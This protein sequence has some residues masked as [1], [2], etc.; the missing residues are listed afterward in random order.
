MFPLVSQNMSQKQNY[1]NTRTNIYST[2]NTEFY[3]GLFFETKKRRLTVSFG[4]A[5]VSLH[6]NVVYHPPDD[7]GD[8]AV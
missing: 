3:C 8:H 7:P 6:W 2:T 4:G 1:F 5:S